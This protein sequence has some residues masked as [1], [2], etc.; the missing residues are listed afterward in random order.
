MTLDAELLEILVCPNDRGELDYQQDPEVLV[1]RTCGYRYPVRDGIPVMLIDEAE[2]PPTGRT[3]S[4]K[5]RGQE[6]EQVTV[7]DDPAAL[8]AADPGGMLDIVTHLADH[9]RE[10]YA[11]GLAARPLPEPDGS[12]L[13]RVLRDGGFGDRRRRAS[14]R[15]RRP[16]LRLP[17]LTVRSPELPEFCG[18]HTLVVASSY[19][20]DTAETLALFEEAVARGC[21]L[22]AI[23]SG[24]ELDRRAAGA[25][26]G[27]CARARRSD[28]AGRV[29]L[30]LARERWVRSRRWGSCRRTPRTSRS[31][32]KSWPVWSRRRART[33]HSARTPPRS[34][35]ASSAT[36][37][38]SSGEPRGSAPSQPTRWTCQFNEN[39]KV[40]AFASVAPRA[41]PQRG[42][43]MVAG[44]GV[45]GSR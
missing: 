33:C 41:R 38:R 16:R 2:K 7:L 35:R 22:V 26:G 45:R 28:A 8:R 17:V 14:P 20:G 13:H 18:P 6:E 40:P 19:S 43:R 39:A 10:G 4:A 32:S 42:R 15:S 11:L 24:G 37:S 36:A 3:A 23:T 12:H 29:R 1:C 21:R 30:P 9:C 44:T 34:S 27:S 25:R 5:A 31:R